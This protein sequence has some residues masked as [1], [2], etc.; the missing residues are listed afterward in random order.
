LLQPPPAQAP[1]QQ[2]QQQQQGIGSPERPSRAFSR[3]SSGTGSLLGQVLSLDPHSWGDQEAPLSR[4]AAAAAAAAAGGPSG[5]A[6][7]HQ[8]Q[9]QGLNGHY[10]AAGGVP[11]A[12]GGMGGYPPSSTSPGGLVPHSLHML[13]ERFGLLNSPSVKSFLLKHRSADFQAVA[14]AAAAGGPAHSSNQLQPQ[15]SGGVSD[16]QR[17]TL[18]MPEPQQQPPPQQ[19]Q[20]QQGSAAGDAPLHPQ[21]Y[22]VGSPELMEPLLGPAHGSRLSVTPLPLGPQLGVGWEPGLGLTLSSPGGHGGLPRSGSRRGL[23]AAAA[24]AGGGVPG[25]VLAPAAGGVAAPAGLGDFQELMEQL[26]EELSC[27]G[28]VT[29][30]EAGADLAAACSIHHVC[31]GGPPV[32][33]GRGWWEAHSEQVRDAWEAWQG[34]AVRRCAQL[35]RLLQQLWQ[36]CAEAVGHSLQQAGRASSR[37]LVSHLSSSGGHMDRGPGAGGLGVGVSPLGRHQAPGYRPWR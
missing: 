23:L 17:L 27:C 14:A 8:L 28:Q 1:Q 37:T 30:E 18:Y 11:M 15:G 16:P 7:P 26:L 33:A 4:E 34:R 9:Q 29:S 31:F 24:A 25:V 20:Q 36:R 6:A 13:P 19:Q 22:W 5:G 10:T 21:L 3:V 32:V 2:Q 35:W 12:L